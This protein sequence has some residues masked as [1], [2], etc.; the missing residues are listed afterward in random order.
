MTGE[1]TGQFHHRVANAVAALRDDPSFA[2]LEMSWNSPA[3]PSIALQ[4]DIVVIHGL[5]GAEI[6]TLINE[7]RAAGRPTL[8]EFADD[9]TAEVPWTRRGL[10]HRDPFV[11]GRQLL[12]GSLADGL[13]LS[14][15]GLRD[16]YAEIN[17]RTAVL[18]NVVEFPDQFPSKPPG[19]V[20][21]WAGTRSHAA[22]LAAIAPAIISFCQRRPDAV[23]ALMGDS[24]LFAMFAALPQPQFI[25]REFGSYEDYRAFLNTLH[26]GVIPLR[27]TQF[28]GGRSDVKLVEMVASGLAVIAQD[29]PAY[30]ALRDSVLL[31]REGAELEQLIDVLY[32]DSEVR[33][34]LAARAWRALRETHC[35]SAV[36]ARHRAWFAEWRPE[37]G[38]GPVNISNDD[39][40]SDAVCSLNDALRAAHTGDKEGALAAMLALLRRNPTYSQ[41]R[42]QATLMLLDLGR[43]A[44]ALET[45][46]PLARCRVFRDAWLTVASGLTDNAE[47]G[48]QIQTPSL[49]AMLTRTNERAADYHARVLESHPFHYFAL[50]AEE[51][52]A[53][54]DGNVARAAG[55]RRRLHLVRPERRGASIAI[56]GAA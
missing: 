48:S 11:V 27:E 5:A 41:A 45:G 7:R 20:V 53:H 36:T 23:F 38:S 12:H 28:N 54:V 14:S 15:R 16:R 33:R 32:D 1:D 55:L 34:R 10:P 22:D 6:A 21:G 31:F 52:R 39:A 26:V 35:A 2:P 19:F 9:L 43:P 47:I 17:P 29:A 40:S 13:Q 18:D 46:A 25:R 50:A 30:H 24:E 42:W 44:A 8:V 37:H 3:A 51:R 4:S 49:R 56:S